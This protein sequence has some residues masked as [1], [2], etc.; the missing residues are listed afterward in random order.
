MYK[1]HVDEIVQWSADES[2]LTDPYEL[3]SYIWDNWED[4]PRNSYY[5]ALARG[6]DRFCGTDEFTT[7][8]RE[9]DQLRQDEASERFMQM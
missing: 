2:G 5:E 8:F 4:E 6:V 7:Y 1:H 3:L 9:M